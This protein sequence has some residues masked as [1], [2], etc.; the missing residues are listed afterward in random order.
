MIRNPEIEKA[1]ERL[2]DPKLAYH[3]FGHIEFVLS[4][5]EK[6]LENCR[7]ENLSLDEEVVYL[8]L[9]FHD[10]GFIEDHVARGHASKEEYSARLAEQILPEFG[11]DQSTIEKVVQAILC[12]HCDGQC[13]CNED[14]AVRAADLS[15]LAADYKVFKDNA[16][17]LM[18]EYKLLTGRD[19]SWQQWKEI[20]VD[21]IGLFLREDMTL[22]AV[23]LDERGESRFQAATRANMDRLL[24]DDSP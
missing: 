5:A 13:R 16:V 7:Q 10:A 22:T 15:G 21:R 9:L 18:Q 6:I 1:A 2:Y 17:K 3:N 12:T 24:A 4:A 14:K 20:A 19:I 8:A 23:E 11:I